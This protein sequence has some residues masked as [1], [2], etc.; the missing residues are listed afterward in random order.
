MKLRVPEADGGSE[1]AAESRRSARVWL[2]NRPCPRQRLAEKRL[3]DARWKQGSRSAEAQL[4]VVRPVPAAYDCAPA[5]LWRGFP[6]RRVSYLF[7]RY[8][9]RFVEP[10][11]KAER[12]NS[13]LRT[14][15]IPIIL[16]QVQR[17]YRARSIWGTSSG[18]EPDR[19]LHPRRGFLTLCSSLQPS[20]P[21]RED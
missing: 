15:G 13:S 12:M 18:G 20:A 17:Q 6:R 14:S 2:R 21:G 7:G 10:P 16:E 11:M 8:Q 1:F 9:T 3:P 19:A 5:A 4:P